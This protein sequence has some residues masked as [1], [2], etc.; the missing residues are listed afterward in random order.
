MTNKSQNEL[1][2]E[3]IAVLGSSGSVGRQAL[4]VAALHGTPVKL[5]SVRS[6]VDCAEEQ[7]RR[8]S[9]ALCAVTD[10]G[11]ARDLA[12]RVR[13]TGTRI[14]PGDEGLLEAIASCGAHTVVNAVLGMAGLR[15]SLA[16]VTSGAR[17]LALSNKESMVI[18]GEIVRAEADR[19]RCDILPVDSEHCAIHQCLA[20]GAHGDV[21]SLILTA[22]GGPFYQFTPERLRDVTLEETL[23]HP[24]WKM[25]AKITV[26]SATLMNKGFEVIEAVRLFDIPAEKI[27]VVVHRESIMHSAVEYIDNMIVAQLGV[28]DMRACVQYA[29]TYPSRI[30]GLTPPLDLAALGRMTFGAPDPD[31]FPLLPA[32]YRAVSAGGATPAVLNASN[33]IAVA[34]FL[35]RRLSFCGIS[36]A[37]SAVTDSLADRAST[38]STLE[39]IL[40]FDTEAR[41]R[42]KELIRSK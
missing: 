11:A 8:F 1:I 6:S 37:V 41:E 42:T 16:A 4:E 30:E 36:E 3:S 18:A 35:D 34:A 38:A 32:A 22:S 2:N 25:G 28:P 13:D 23:A 39:E 10:E 15:P 20:S 5:I 21:K 17:R 40:S 19:C 12:I 24:T 14:I 27:K 9:P 31:A 7:I 33:E 29:L 26:D